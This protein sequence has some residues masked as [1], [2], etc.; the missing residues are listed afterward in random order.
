MP[1]SKVVKSNKRRIKKM[2]PKKSLRAKVLSIVNNQRETKCAVRS[3]AATAV[4]KGM[5][6]FADIGLLM[7][8]IPQGTGSQQRIG[9]TIT[10]T[11]LVIRGYYMVQ[12]PNTSYDGQRIQL[13]QFINSQKG[14]KNAYSISLGPVTG[15]SA[16]NYN[17]LLEPSQ[18]YGGSPADYMTPVN[19]TAFSCRRDRRWTLKSGIQ[20]NDPTNNQQS[21][22]K[23]FVY[24]TH[25][26]TFGKGKK[27]YYKTD[28]TTGDAVNPVNF[29]YFLT[30]SQNSMS[31]DSGSPAQVLRQ[32]T[33]S[34][35]YFDS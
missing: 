11:K 17:N 27:L 15:G 24:F 19:R 35:Y 34:A 32:V 26:L 33:C 21:G 4:T 31:L 23:T 16:Y 10:L 25:T 2:V 9:N 18:A 30:D 5:S 14:T 8:E 22:D 12:F 13:R 1:A 6:N 20:T 29:P 3:D 28:A 7:P